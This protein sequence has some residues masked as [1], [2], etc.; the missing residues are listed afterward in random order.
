MLDGVSIVEEWTVF[1]LLN[2]PNR[3]SATM[4]HLAC[5]RGTRDSCRPV[6]GI[7]T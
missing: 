3:L 4:R 5:D 2:V 7:A 6:A 1:R